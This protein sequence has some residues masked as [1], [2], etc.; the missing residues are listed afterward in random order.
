MARLKRWKYWK[1][2]RI[3]RKIAERYGHHDD[4]ETQWYPFSAGE[5]EEFQAY[6]EKLA[7]WL[8]AES[9][10]AVYKMIGWAIHD[11]EEPTLE[12]GKHRIWRIS[13]QAGREAGLID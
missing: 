8:G 5:N 13:K 3:L 6:C 2:V 12:S 4:W 1:R 11:G 9:G 7:R 10:Q